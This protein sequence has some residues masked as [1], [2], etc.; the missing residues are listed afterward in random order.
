[1]ELQ[2]TTRIVKSTV[3]LSGM[4]G[5][6]NDLRL[7]TQGRATYSIHFDRYESLPGGPPNDDEEGFAPVVVP[8]TPTPKGK[9]S[10]V[11]LPESDYG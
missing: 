9:D 5:Y 4:L 1:M 11:A 6:A 10:G 7:R 8:R 2:G 3:P